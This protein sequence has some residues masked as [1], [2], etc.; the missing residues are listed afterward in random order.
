MVEI[1]NFSIFDLLKCFLIEKLHSQKYCNTSLLKMN[2]A[3]QAESPS[4]KPF[5]LRLQ[6]KGAFTVTLSK[7]FMLYS[8]TGR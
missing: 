1:V 6:Y 5:L 3:F 2:R 8:K 4:L 7:D